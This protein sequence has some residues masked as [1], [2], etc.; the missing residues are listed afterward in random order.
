MIY[1][2]DLIN[3]TEVVF[4]LNDIK[5]RLLLSNES[6]EEILKRYYD[7]YSSSINLRK[8]DIKNII[9]KQSK[10]ITMIETKI[11]NIN[12]ATSSVNEVI[13]ANS[14]NNISGGKL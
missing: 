1:G 7:C 12:N 2:T 9:I 10:L 13:K 5:K 8:K 4:L 14:N 6:F 11:N 3:S